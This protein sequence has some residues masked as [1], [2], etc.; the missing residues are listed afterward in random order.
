MQG[1]LFPKVCVDD[2][3][4]LH[5]AR[6]LNTK[7]DTKRNLEIL[8]LFLL[9]SAELRACQSEVDG[10]RFRIF[11]QNIVKLLFRASSYYFVAPFT[12]VGLCQWYTVFGTDVC[13]VVL[14][15]K[16]AKAWLVLLLPY[17]RTFLFEKK[18]MFENDPRN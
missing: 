17:D 12:V 13:P 16:V 6:A 4:L 14:L 3:N 9:G 15:S 18:C 2:S 5:L 7:E 8:H 10:K 1:N 11:L